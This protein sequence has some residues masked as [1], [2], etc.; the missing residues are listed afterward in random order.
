MQRQDVPLL[1]A[2]LSE[3]ASESDA[4]F[5]ALLGVTAVG[6]ALAWGS[7]AYV[8]VRRR[9]S[10]VAATPP[11]RES[12]VPNLVFLALFGAVCVFFFHR[13][14][15]SSSIEGWRLRRMRSS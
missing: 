14:S 4:L 3:H 2:A 12:R 11:E 6:V 13:G 15:P 10:R 8:V 9:R 5:Q 1:P 7:I